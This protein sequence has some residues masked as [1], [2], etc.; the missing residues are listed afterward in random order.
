MTLIWSDD[1]IQS[2]DNTADYIEKEFG[3]LRSIEFLQDVID[4]ANG[5]ITN[6]RSGAI[7]DLLEGARHEYRSVPIGEQSRLIYRIDGNVVR[8]EF[9]WNNRMNPITLRKMFP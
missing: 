6:P 3:I 5:L 1:A 4:R 2:V 7:D 8:L 9:L